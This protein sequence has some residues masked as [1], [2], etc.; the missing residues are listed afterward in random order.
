MPISFD[1][2]PDF[3]LH[4]LFRPALDVLDRLP[5]W[6]PA[7]DAGA[8]WDIDTSSAR[9]AGLP[10]RPV[11]ETLTDLWAWLRGR[12]EGPA[13]AGRRPRPGLPDDVERAL[14]G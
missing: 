1:N 9:A 2:T 6:V 12:P 10:S 3:T 4:G 13:R 5:F 11:E 14:L 8:L 7:A